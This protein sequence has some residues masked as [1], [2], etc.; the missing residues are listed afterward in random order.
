MK[1]YQKKDAPQWL[2]DN[3]D[4]LLPIIQYIVTQI[5]KVIKSK[6]D[7]RNRK[8]KEGNRNSNRDT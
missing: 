7:V 1:Q 3:W 8:N 6:K 4:K 5:I 2:L